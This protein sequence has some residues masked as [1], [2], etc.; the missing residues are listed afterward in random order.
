M[1][2][3]D[4]VSRET[5]GAADG[6][7]DLGAAAT[8]LTLYHQRGQHIALKGDLLTNAGRALYQGERD[9]LTKHRAAIV[10]LLS[11][12]P[13]TWRFVL[14][15]H[16]PGPNQYPR[17]HFAKSALIK[18][19][20]NRMLALALHE[21]PVVPVPYARVLYT[22]EYVDNRWWYDRDN[23]WAS[24][25]Y[26]QDALVKGGVLLN[27]TTKHLDSAVNLKLGPYRRLLIEV[28]E[29]RPWERN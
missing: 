4:Q 25:K 27:D 20:K 29:V 5:A 15:G 23:A 7:L 6:A 13:Q 28:T 2:N 19:W 11:S 18:P 9:L 10:L 22:F 3:G 21:R 16:P 8:L 12:P 17:N 14:D 24:L 1:I 26:V